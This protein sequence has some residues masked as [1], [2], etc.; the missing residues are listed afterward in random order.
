MENK[1][2]ILILIFVIISYVQCG[3]STPKMIE[4]TPTVEVT[5]PPATEATFL[6]QVYNAFS[7]ALV[8][9]VEEYTAKL[10]GTSAVAKLIH[11]LL[12]KN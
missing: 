6:R 11:S 5:E 7:T 9:K 12:F 4:I 2:Q 3:G 10:L 8:L 1:F